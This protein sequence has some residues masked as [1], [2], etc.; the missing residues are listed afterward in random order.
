[1]ERIAVAGV[2]FLTLL[3]HAQPNSTLLKQDRDGA[4]AVSLTAAELASLGDPFFELILDTASPPVRLDRIEDLLQP[5]RSKRQTFVVDE[6]IA[7]PARGQQRR[8][9]LS[10]AGTAPQGQVLA[11]NVMLSVA[12]DSERFSDDMRFI[13]AWGWDHRRGRY[14]YYKLDRTGIS[15]KRL[16][17]K[18]RGNSDDADLLNPA[19]REGTCMQCHLNGAPIMKELAFPWNNW[20]SFQSHADYLTTIAPAAQR[21]PVSSDPRLGSRLLGAERLE[22]G[23]ILPSITQFNTRR[24]NSLLKRADADGNI[25]IENGKATVLE[26]RRLLRHLFE[27]TEVNFGSSGI[28]SGLHPFRDAVMS[29]PTQPIKPP[30]T[31]F[32][33]AP[34]MG[35]SPAVSFVTL[36]ITQARQFDSGI[37]ITP[38]EYRQLVK[39]FRLEIAGRPGDADFAWFTPEA[40]HIDNDMVDRMLRRGAVTPE[41]V[42]AALAVDLERPIF[43]APRASLLQ[44]VPKSYQFEPTTS[45]PARGRHPDALTLSVIAAIQHTEQPTGSA[46]AEFLKLLQ[47]A[48]PVAELSSRVDAYA[49]RVKAA[50]K[51]RRSQELRRIFRELA[52]RRLQILASERF[53]GLDETGDRLLPLP[54][55]ADR[56]IVGSGGQRRGGL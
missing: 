18:L 22:T 21:W 14:N 52:H 12:F 43:S 28:K 30:V 6:N 53:A 8:A 9:V 46:A 26:A 3:S 5:D 32:L 2:F 49:A 35:G 45:P 34:L 11:T 29:G 16:T 17:W 44:F 38:T 31:F 50:I 33:N 19:D 51:V 10:Y 55:E 39:E 36:G 23:G 20:H 15:D 41:F 37:E 56:P 42:A 13:E 24:F 25:E 27:T 47:S 48:D 40:S 4:P 1:M 54:P 7:N